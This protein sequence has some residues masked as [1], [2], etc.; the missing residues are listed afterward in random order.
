MLQAS[1]DQLLDRSTRGCHVM[2]YPTIIM[3]IMT[4]ARTQMIIVVMSIIIIIIIL[5][6]FAVI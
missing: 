1:A 5:V 4:I 6:I 3:T 2:E